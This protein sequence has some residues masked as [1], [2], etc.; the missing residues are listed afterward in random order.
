MNRMLNYLQLCRNG[1]LSCNKNE[2]PE[3]TVKP[4]PPMIPDDEP[5]DENDVDNN[6]Q[7]QIFRIKT[8]MLKIKHL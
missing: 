3:P 6:L 2:L 5:H 8:L 4:K 7:E 1:A